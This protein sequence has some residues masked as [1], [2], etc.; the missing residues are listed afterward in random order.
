MTLSS[1]TLAIIGTVIFF[2]LS[3]V[4]LYEVHSMN[5]RQ[6]AIE[7]QIVKQQELADGIT[8]AMASWATKADIEKLAKDS[9]TN[10]E[11]I[12]NDLAKLNASVTA[13]NVSRSAS[14]GQTN[15]NVPSTDVVKDPNATPSTILCDGKEVPCGDP[16][17]YQMTTQK[18]SLN[19]QFGEL[20]VPIGSVGFSASKKEPWSIDI[21]PREYNAVTVIGTDEE[22]RMYAYNKFTIHTKDK[23]YEVPVTSSQ[24]KQEYPSPKFTLLNPRLYIGVNSGIN[25]TTV[26]GM[27]G[28]TLNLQVASL[29]KY[30][31]QP[32]LSILQLGVGYDAVA[33]TPT[34]VV[35]PVAYNIGK[36]IPLM[37]N[38]YVGP[39]LSVGFN[40]DIGAA[41]GIGAGL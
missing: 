1:K 13:V 2:I 21:L 28:P 24:I 39:Q 8:R 36:H 20:S 17:G 22:Q 32:D 10:L 5:A 29:G 6:S 25:T 27:A 14:K 23:D 33:K 30:K 16:F 9:N 37:N 19:E 4:V 38:L 40:G 12:K 7:T 26:T 18:L 31:T 41:V 11:A 3:S 35:T 15:T 34:A